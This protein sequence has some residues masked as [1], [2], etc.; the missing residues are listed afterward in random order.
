MILDASYDRKAFQSLVSNLLPDMTFDVRAIEAQSDSFISATMLGRSINL[1]LHVLEI[2]VAKGVENRVSIT[3]NAFTLLKNYG[4]YNAVVVFRSEKSEQWRISLMTAT[5]KL[6]SG[7]SVISISNPKRNSFVLGP[8]AKIK[9]PTK[10][11]ISSGKVQNLQE[12]QDRFSIE[13][14]NKEFFADVARLYRKLVGDH[15]EE[16]LPLEVKQG[17]LRIPESTETELAKQQFSVR[18]IGRLVFCWFLRQ[19]K[20]GKELPLLPNDFFDIPNSTNSFYHDKLEPLFF[21]TLNKPA[22]DRLPEFSSE[23]YSLVPYLNGGLFYP[24]PGHGG[25]YYSLDLKKSKDLVVP[26]SWFIEFFELLD[27]FNFTVDENSSFDTDLSVDPEMLGRIFENLLA[28]INPDTGE[29]AR[30]STGSFYTP[31]S[32]VDYM[33]DRTI[34]AFLLRK[35]DISAPKL[36]ALISYDQ[37]DDDEYP[38]NEE[39][40][41][42]VT[43]SLLKFRVLDPACGSGAFPIGILQKVVWIQQQ[44]DPNAEIWLEM[45]LSGMSIEL[46]RHL[47]NQVKN[48]NFDYLRKLGVI[49]ETLF[50][51]DIQP[52][53]TEMSRLRCFLTLIVEEDVKDNLENRGIQPLPNLEFKFIT[54]NT[55]MDLSEVD[56]ET[57]NYPSM[58]DD[59][60]LILQLK[61]MRDQYF[62]STGKY[63]NKL[64]DSFSKVQDEMKNNLDTIQYGVTSKAFQK[65]AE[66]DPFGVDGV[67]WFDAEWMF[68]TNKFDAV[69]CNPPYVGEKGHKEMFREIRSSGLRDYYQ[70]KMDLFYFFFH[71]AINHVDKGGIITFITTNYFPTALGARNLRNDI[72]NRTTVLEI[73]NFNELRIFESALGQH[74]MVTIL[75]KGTREVDAIF[76]MVTQT[77]LIKHQDLDPILHKSPDQAGIFT[78]SQKSIFDG[79]EAYIRFPNSEVDSILEKMANVNQRLIDICNVNQGV[80]TGADRFSKRHHEM[81]PGIKAEVGAGIFR[82]QEGDWADIANS[83]NAKPFFKNSAIRR[84][85]SD[86]EP[87]SYLL[88]LYQ[89]RKPTKPELKY[90]QTFREILQGRGG[91]VSGDYEWW[92]IH[93]SRRTEIFEG[94]KIVCPQRSGLN[95]F[96]FNEQSWY[97][98]ADVYFITAKNDDFDLKPVLSLLNS[99]LYY[100]W[101][102]N[103]GKRKGEALELFQ[104]PLSELPIPKLP[105]KSAI[106]LSRLATLA[107]DQAGGG[108]LDLLSETEAK[109]DDIVFE[110]FNLSGEERIAVLDF[111]SLKKST[112]QNLEFDESTD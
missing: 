100:C 65:L 10:L 19:K 7:K 1:D 60:K 20:S 52:I 59:N 45:Q 27:R 15:S 64:V 13:V 76:N 104:I 78:Y 29:A 18:L 112:V 69:I 88:Y 31:R 107:I 80:I 90:L 89:E 87:S 82:V 54:A 102:Y 46:Q 44:V 58:F 8:S 3:R 37:M 62:T 21:E 51:V 9:T 57:S 32:V 63:R 68:G 110:C 14:V 47:K 77:G 34:F 11:L 12:L 43:L 50:G 70:G 28:E 86:S 93:R 36:K 17:M 101:F 55:L 67:D 85:K 42:K 105:A 81:Y 4:I 39:E 95:T 92:S 24:K 2:L 40:K 71:I 30:K 106:E 108:K 6:D 96:A 23:P 98:S 109:I 97:G 91:V 5:A 56:E 73:I 25:D 53:A 41:R 75:E 79:P 61:D 72:K 22:A 33:V 49:R 48:E 94:P 99:K 35:T 103:R 84:W 83:T 38:L 74:N 16:I 26:N 111:W 66:W